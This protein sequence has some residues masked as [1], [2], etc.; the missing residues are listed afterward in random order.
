MRMKNKTQWTALLITG[1]AVLTGCQNALHDENKRLVSQN[2]ELQD[3]LNQAEGELGNRPDA[4]QVAAMQAGLS[5]RDARIAQLEQQLRTPTPGTSAP[6]IDGI[7]TEF[8]ARSGE[9]TVRVPGDVLFDSGVATVKPTARATLDKIADALEGQYKGKVIRVEGHTDSDPLV[10]TRAQWTDN[11]G[12]SAARALA[13]ARYLESRGVDSKRLS[14]VGHG[15]YVPRGNEKSR[16][17]RV[18]IIVVTK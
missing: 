12:L 3:R 5:E 10:R 8:D 4:S 6:G 15:E 1:L 11:R 13:V 9:L 18:E 16:N 17:R 14:V 2:R 7:E